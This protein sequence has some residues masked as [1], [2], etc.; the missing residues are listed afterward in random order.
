MMHDKLLITGFEPFADFATNPSWHAAEAA[1]IEFGPEVVGAC[2]PVDHLAARAMLLELLDLHQPAACLCMGLCPEDCFRLEMLA[3]K[4]GE[5]S[6][7]PGDDLLVGR[8]PWEQIE[9]SLSQAGANCRQS[10]DAGR[11]V[12][13]STYWTL[14]DWQQ[15]SGSAGHAFFLHVPHASNLYPVGR[16]VD[17]VRQVVAGYRS[18]QSSRR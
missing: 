14:L 12:C 6:D 16:T 10:T 1:A 8:W 9:E 2:L 3:R 7:L 15:R 17:C 13:E 5:F 11:Y 4:P 18:S